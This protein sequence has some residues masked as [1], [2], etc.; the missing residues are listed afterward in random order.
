MGVVLKAF[1]PS[2]H[3]LVAIKVLAAAVAG[4]ATARRRFTREAQAAAAVCHDHV[5]AVHGVSEADGLP[6]LVMQYV[7]GE[8]LQERLDRAGPLPVEEAVRLGIQTASGL[9]AAHA[10]GLIHRDVKPANLLLEDG[11]VRVKITDFGLA[12]TAD[13]VG[14]TQAGVVAGTPEYM[15]PEQA[16]GEQVDPRADLFSLGSVLYACCTGRPPFRGSTSVAVLH[17]VND[18]EP[19][20]V[21]ALNADV[22]AWLEALIARLM[23]KDP[24]QRFPS[25]A[26]VAALLEGYLAHL[27]QPTTV[28]APE[29]PPPPSAA[30]TRES[31]AEAGGAWHLL[32]LLAPLSPGVLASLLLVGL[33]LFGLALGALAPDTEKEQA[34]QHLAV[35]FRAGL[36]KIPPFEYFGPDASS[37]T[38]TDAQG[39]RIDV[40]AIREDPNPLGLDLPLRIHGNF[41][42]VLGY[43]LLAIDDPPPES[44]AGVQV[45]LVFASAS[46]RTAAITRLRKPPAADKAPLYTWVGPRGE[47]FGAARIDQAPDGGEKLD[48]QNYRAAEPAG[49]FRL[50]RNGSQLQYWVADGASEYHLIRSMEIGTDDVQAVRLMCFTGYKLG[51]VDVRFTDLV[52]DADQV[53]S[54]AA[55]GPPPPGAAPPGPESSGSP[56]SHYRALGVF[57][58]AL[59]TVAGLVLL[60]VLQRRRKAPAPTPAKAAGPQAAAPPA[61]PRPSPRGPRPGGGKKFPHPLWLAALVVPAALGVGLVFWLAGGGSGAAPRPAEVQD[62]EQAFKGGAGGAP[63]FELFG[64]DADGRVRFEPD[65]LRITLPPGSQSDGQGTGV[66]STFGVKGDFEITVRFEILQEVPP[67][68]P[69]RQTRFSLGV[70]LDRS[71]FNM[72]TLSRKIAEKSGPGFLSWVTLWNEEAG[73]NRAKAKGVPTSATTGRLRLARTGSTLSYS[74]SEGPDGNFAV[75]QQYPFGNEDL[76]DIRL[77]AATDDARGSLDVRVTDFHAHAESLPNLPAAAPAKARSTG[78]L[79]AAALL[80][81]VIALPLLVGLGVVLSVRRGR[82]PEKGPA[83]TPAAPTPAEPKAAP[84]SVSFPCSGCGKVLKVRAALAGKKGKC[85]HCAAV[86]LIPATAAG[87][88][89]RTAP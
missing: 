22:P 65:G 75:L 23:A 57:A 26:E 50:V 41:E 9:A 25:A 7:A 60:Y 67:V 2:L 63:G 72:A 38:R 43:E 16:R 33:G 55:S 51:A 59:L 39:L 76:K 80:G 52:I 56:R 64:P 68:D 18:Q 28:P 42:I 6:Y 79:P 15:A 54:Q 48:V 44:G 78:W 4:S 34:R 5:V 31:G 71:G 32:G 11:L 21:R 46:P 19:M 85:P 36:D 8:S 12:R 74:A 24:A 30:Q 47:T 82:L 27:R 29:L 49:K 3:R 17:Q 10:Q 13:D 14:L 69:Q 62:Y 40:P 84:A 53:R 73:K 86:V 87:E 89:G 58:A 45:R 77:V 81:L 61:R 83:C 37:V 35:D 88:S 1:D 70:L 20:P 66:V